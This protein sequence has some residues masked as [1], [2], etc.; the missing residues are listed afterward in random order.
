[1]GVG[2]RN[3]HDICTERLM[4]TYTQAMNRN[5]R[6]RNRP[7]PSGWMSKT[8]AMETGMQMPVS[9]VKADKN[10][11]EPESKNVHETGVM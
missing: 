9:E 2:V 5:A 8:S 6:T 3:R 11:P 1:V 4:V 7:G 10:K